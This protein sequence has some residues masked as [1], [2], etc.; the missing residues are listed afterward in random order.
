MIRRDYFIRMIEALGQELRRIESLKKE[1]RYGEA[2]GIVDDEVKRMTGRDVREV[3]QLSETA[4]LALL[5]E[6]ET[7]GLVREKAWLLTTLLKEAGDLAVAQ[8]RVEEGD[9]YYL[10]GLHLLLKV[11][12]GADVFDFPE[13]VPRV[14]TLVEAISPSA[15]SLETKA[16]LMEHYE[17]TGQFSRAE[18][19]L[20]TILEADPRNPDA[21][22]FGVEFYE[23]V[24]QQNDERLLLGNLPRAEVV[25]GLAEMRAGRA[26]L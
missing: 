21:W 3:V 8:D 18:D 4:L 2:G 13:F 26:A 22:D 12:H 17:T 1:E 25:A 24:S 15:L 23:R 7:T 20:H 11:L 5:I 9:R 14:E 10:K 16:L 19:A 6:G